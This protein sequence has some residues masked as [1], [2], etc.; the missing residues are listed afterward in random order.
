M[1]TM[2]RRGC[3]I[4]PTLLLACATGAAAQQ[5]PEPKRDPPPAAAMVC[6]STVPEGGPAAP[7][8]AIRASVNRLTDAATQAL[9]VGDLDGADEFLAR[10]LAADPGAAEAA[11]LRGRIAADRSDATAAVGWFCRYLE[12]APSGPSAPEARRRLEAAVADGAAGPM[13][14][15]FQEGIERYDAGDLERADE[16]FAWLLEARPRV[17]AAAY[18]RG[19]AL[20][21]L[22]RPGPARA[23]LA[24]YLELSPDAEDRATV[25]EL[26]LSLARNRAVPSPASAFLLG[27]V[28]PG[29]GQFYTGRPAL[30]LTVTALA[31]GA[32]AFGYFFERTTVL[33]RDGTGPSCPPDA[34]LGEETERPLLVAG[35][36]AGG[37]LAL[38]AAVEAALHAGRDRRT[39]VQVPVRRSQTRIE[40]GPSA[41]FSPTSLQLSLVRVRF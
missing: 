36:A 39:R 32:A 17:A 33:C 16:R 5:V 6:P 29:G 40:A 25:E 41:T 38:L 4:V 2:R 24:R 30:G 12:L 14:A 8:A 22:G 11:Y 27:A 10:A 23:E 31:G 7:D 26:L 19:L 35:L 28:L 1:T 34:V 18:N 9:I 3:R 37:A 21:G 20:A 13:Y 15:A